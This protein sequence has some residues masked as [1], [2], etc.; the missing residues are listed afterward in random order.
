MGIGLR[1]RVAEGWYNFAVCWDC[2]V[3][4]V[5]DG[6]EALRENTGAACVGCEGECSGE[7]LAR[8]E[9]SDDALW[10]DTRSFSDNRPGQNSKSSSK[11]KDR[12]ASNFTRKVVKL[13]LSVISLM[14]R[15]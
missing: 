11:S 7:L 10:M 4:R 9:R 1:V 5:K 8:E 2:K 13:R 6:D 12:P 3:G 14:E 15:I